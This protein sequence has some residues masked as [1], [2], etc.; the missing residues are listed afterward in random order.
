MKMIKSNGIY[1]IQT[2]NV[3]KAAFRKTAEFMRTFCE[4]RLNKNAIIVCT[5][6]ACQS[7]STLML[8]WLKLDLHAKLTFH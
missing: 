8:K 2:L 4:G 5:N 1:M 6:M 7:E 3:P